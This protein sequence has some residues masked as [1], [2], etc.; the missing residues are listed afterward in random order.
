[1][2][3]APLTKEDYTFDELGNMVFTREYHLKRGHCCK[4]GCQH[5]PY[6]FK[7]PS[8]GKTSAK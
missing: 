4:S 3:K 5:C 7:K 6:G 1:M 2:K 8:V